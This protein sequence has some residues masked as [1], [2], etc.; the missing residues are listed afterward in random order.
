MLRL[1]RI[2][3]PHLR[4]RRVERQLAGHTRRVRIEHVRRD[5]AVLERIPDEMRFRQVRGGMDALQKRYDTMPPQA[6]CLMPE[7]PEMLRYERLNPTRGV[8][9]PVTPSDVVV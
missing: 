4:Q 5:A 8:M 6:S 9:R 2:L 7:R 1:R 3:D